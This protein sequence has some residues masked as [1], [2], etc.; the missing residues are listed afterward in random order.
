M[1]AIPRDRRPDSTLA[2]LRDPYRYIG[3]ECRR[4]GTDLFEARLLL[5]KTIC[6]TGAEAAALFYDERR[7]LR[8][9]AA[10]MRVQRSLFGVGGVQGLDDEAH[11]RRKAMFMSIMTPE[12]IDDLALMV[13][14]ALAAAARTWRGAG[15]VVLFEAL[16][17]P[18]LRAVCQWAGV[19]LTGDEVGRRTEDVVALFDAAGDVGPRHL[20]ARLA[21]RRS[22]RWI[23]EVVR[24]IRDARLDPPPGSAACIVALHRDCDERLLDER[25]AAVELLSVLRPTVAVSVYIVHA[26]HAL[27]CHGRSVLEDDGVDDFVHEVRRYYPFFPAVVARVRHDFRWRDYRFPAGRRVL[28]DL[29]GTNRDERVWPS[30]EEFRPARFRRWDRS[31]YNYIPQGGGDFLAGH[32]CA[33]EYLTIAVMRAAVE[34]LS[35][36]VVYEVPEQDLDIDY[37]RLPALPRSR[38]RMGAVRPAQAGASA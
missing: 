20:A 3:R 21:R 30:P 8:H 33:G 37:R 36:E 9:G 17:E 27:H 28:L 7:F 31:P 32:R 16:H 25:I 12:A 13:R 24:R 1:P 23:A 4:H 19:P 34:F 26:A 38:F 15:E 14:Q 5:K 35:R 29:Y 22:E 2:L 10:P 18:L 11:R 6:M